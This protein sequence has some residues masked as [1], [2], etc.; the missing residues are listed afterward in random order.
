MRTHL[1]HQLHLGD[2]SWILL[3][4]VSKGK[5]GRLNG[6]NSIHSPRSSSPSTAAENVQAFNNICAH[7]Y[8]RAVG[9]CIPV[10]QG[11]AEKL[12]S[13]QTSE[14]MQHI[15][16]WHVLV[17]TLLHALNPIEGGV[18]GGGG[19]GGGGWGGSLCS[20]EISET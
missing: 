7:F 8:H 6:R 3:S 9:S 1:R 11:L 19:G 14:K 20:T 16:L 12:P 13:W 4:S 15:S 18:G 5:P 10:V 2:K 17:F